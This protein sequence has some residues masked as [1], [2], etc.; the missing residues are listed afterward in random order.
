[1]RQYQQ[2]NVLTPPSSPKPFRLQLIDGGVSYKYEQSQIAD[3][4]SPYSLNTC[5][6]DRG[7]LQKRPG[8]AEVYDTTLG[9]GAVHYIY[10]YKLLAGTTKRIIHHGTKLYTQTGTTQPIEIYSGVANAK[11]VAFTFG[12]VWYY[13]DG[14]NFIQYNGTTAAAVVG[15]APIISEARTPAGVGTINESLNLMSNSWR[16][17]FNGNNSDTAFTLSYAGLSTVTVTATIAG[18]TKT[19][20]THFTVN[21]TT[22]VVDFAAGTSPH[23]APATGTNNVIIQAEKTGLNDSTYIKKN[24]YAVIFGGANDTRVFLTG[25][26]ASTVYYCEVANALYWPTPNWFMVGS[27]ADFNTG[28]SVMY[29]QLV[30][31]KQRS[32]SRIEYV[33]STTMDFASYPL[34]STV[35]CDMPYTIQTIDNNI[36]FCN[37]YAGA[38]VMTATD[39]RTEKN[40]A[41]LSGNINGGYG[42]AGLLDETNANLLLATSVDWDGKYIICVGSNAYV[43]DYA[44]TPFSYTG[45]ASEDEE[46]LAWF[47]WDNINAN[48][49]LVDDGTCY[50][51]DRDT[52]LVQELTPAIFSDNGVAINSYWKCKLLHFGLPEWEKHISDLY[53]RTREAGNVALTVTFYDRKG[54]VLSTK[55]A[56]SKSF[57]WDY[58][59]WDLFTWEAYSVPPT[60]HFKPKVKK[61]VYFQFMVSNNEVGQNLSIMDL[62]ACYSLTRKTKG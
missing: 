54:A 13:I 3:S 41:P 43:W 46:R 35:G 14:T 47:V 24:K 34:N 8:Q 38:F 4:Q 61:S 31:L 52:G 22:G 44:L 51:G 1:M 12:D 11:G 26:D 15:Y 16:D 10:D 36:V 49:W 7:A 18:V 17:S 50:Y 28:F 62:E 25:G 60:L 30:L 58:F 32:I 37:S 23:G 45:K 57:S 2:F 48:C 55:T 29:D 53:I 56:T 9:A 5:C 42:R 21:R 20:G 19:E 27:D 33:G 6:D 40:V 39:T 59:S